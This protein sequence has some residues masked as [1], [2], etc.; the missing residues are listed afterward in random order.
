L[1]GDEQVEEQDGAIFSR[2]VGEEAL[3]VGEGEGRVVA[4]ERDEG[5]LGFTVGQGEVGP[6]P[7]QGGD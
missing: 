2:G 5:D 3:A 6:L 1:P 4:L 7:M